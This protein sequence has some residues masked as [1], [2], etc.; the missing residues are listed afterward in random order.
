VL[1]S[2]ILFGPEN[3]KIR[4]PS[5]V[6]EPCCLAVWDALNIGVGGQ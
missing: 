2:V 4:K 1:A 5:A 6:D 3:C